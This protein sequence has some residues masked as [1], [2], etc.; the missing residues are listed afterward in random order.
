MQTTLPLPDPSPAQPPPGRVAASRSGLAPGGVAP[1]MWRQFI[2]KA[3]RGDE[4]FSALCVRFR[5]SRKTGYK[6]LNRFRAQGLAGLQPRSRRPK[7]SPR[8]IPAAVVERMIELRCQNPHWTSSQV[9]ARLH[10]AGVA[11]LPAQ[12][13][14]SVILRRRLSASSEEVAGSLAPA[15][16]NF[17]WTV[18]W[19][20]PFE[21][22]NGRQVH[23]AL[24]RDDATGFIVGTALLPG[25]E[26]GMTLFLTQGF[27]RYGLPRHVAIP[28][29][30]GNLASP[31][32][33]H[34][35]GTVRLMQ[36]GVG[37]DFYREPPPRGAEPAG[38]PATAEEGDLLDRFAAHSGQLTARHAAR[39]LGQLRGEWNFCADHQDPGRPSP[40]SVYRP[41][42]RLM[43]AALREPAY[44]PDATVRLVSEKGIITFQRRLVYV[45]RAFAGQT[46]EMR[47]ASEPENFVV[48]F[49]GQTLGRVNLTSAQA[50]GTK[51]LSLRSS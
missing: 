51:S 7:T 21:L 33:L 2:T 42:I 13:T 34:T 30:R 50:G 24:V 45:G 15:D 48:L 19:G 38:H 17:R 10:E 1:E 23:P 29:R 3:E 4:P 43:P 8:M 9:R 41:G 26:E 35:P 25:R 44:A 18:Q 32:R 47:A 28:V 36:L 39:L 31:Q 37:V 27:R 11:P 5:I 12:S 22:A 14:I 40:S 49:A 6:W 46:V 16:P 20:R